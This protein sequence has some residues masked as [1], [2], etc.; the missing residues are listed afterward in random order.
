MLPQGSNG[1]G[2]L[3]L[4]KS[5]N[6]AALVESIQAYQKGTSIGR[7]DIYDVAASKKQS[8]QL[9]TFIL[10]FFYGFVALITAIGVA[11]IFNTTFTSIALRKREFAMLRSVGM[12]PRDFL[13]MI[14]FESIFYGIKALLYGLP[15]SFAMMYLI[16]WVMSDSFRVKFIVPW[17]SVLI[18]VVGVFAI[19]SSTMLYASSKVRHENIIDVLKMENY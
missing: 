9:E 6:P 2:V 12:T 7:V 4:I 16:H 18:V 14:N 8:R 11:N 13:K 19:V 10:V 17:N 3:Q 15:I 1:S 5:S